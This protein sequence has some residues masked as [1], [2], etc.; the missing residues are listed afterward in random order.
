MTTTEPR[1]RSLT[2]AFWLLVVGAVMLMAGGL[3]AITLGYDL[4]REA[5]PSSFSD[6]AVHQLLVFRRGAG[7]ICVVAGLALAFL[8]GRTRTGD[9]RYR[10]ATLGL[11]LAIIVLVG[12][13]QVFVNI[14]L[15]ALLSLLP[16]IVG[17]LLLSRPP[18]A[19][20]FS[21]QPDPKSDV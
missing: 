3:L 19:K 11:G 8:T 7:V 12:I 5:L 16:I 21:P 4:L 17:T 1:P 2:I 13:M 6:Q 20:W 18:V 14:G 9:V 10:R 15:I